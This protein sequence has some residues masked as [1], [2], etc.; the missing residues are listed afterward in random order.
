[1]VCQRAGWPAA[2]QATRFS[3]GLRRRLTGHYCSSAAGEQSIFCL[4]CLF[5]NI[6]FQAISTLEVEEK[7]ELQQAAGCPGGRWRR[8]TGH[9]RSSAAGEQFMFCFYSV[10]YID[11]Q[12]SFEN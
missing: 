12:K 4:F 5:K 8:L 7:V 3:W 6:K 11:D 1:V 9:H 10:F 2:Q